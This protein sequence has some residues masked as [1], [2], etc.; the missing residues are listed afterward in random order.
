MFLQNIVKIRSGVPKKVVGEKRGSVK[1]RRSDCKKPGR[2]K[3]PNFAGESHLRISSSIA[4]FLFSCILATT[5][6][7]H[8]PRRF[9]PNRRRLHTATHQPNR[10]APAIIT[11]IPHTFTHF[12]MFKNFNVYHLYE[13]S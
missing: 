1:K 5:A 7:H 6:D 8:N 4:H 10:F 12:W 13:Q 11:L 9:G 3:I 2:L